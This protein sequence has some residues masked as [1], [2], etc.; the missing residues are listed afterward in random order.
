MTDK[1]VRRLI[2][3]I[4]INAVVLLLWACFSVLLVRGMIV[5]AFRDES[6]PLLN[7]IINGRDVHTLDHYLDYW[8]HVAWS[9]G[10]VLAFALFIAGSLGVDTAVQAAT[11]CGGRSD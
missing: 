9:L 1:T 2:L 6:H 4:V 10:V 5:R 8:A 11:G 3:V 7:S